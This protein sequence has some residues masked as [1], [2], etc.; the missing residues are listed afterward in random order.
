M[1]G[2]II[3]ILGNSV[4]L[5]VANMFV[6]GFVVRGNTKEYLMAGV[7][8][9]LLNIIIR[10]VLKTITLPIIILT[11]GIFILILDAVMLWIVDYVFDFVQIQTLMA[12]VWTTILVG[13]INW[14]IHKTTKLI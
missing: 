7:L 13:I 9:G 2:F 6:P 3:R 8:L 10:P 14:F 11:L 12:L 4:A 1:I 5:Y